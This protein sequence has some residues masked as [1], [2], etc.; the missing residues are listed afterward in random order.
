MSPSKRRPRSKRR[1]SNHAV[2]P[3]ATETRGTK[4]FPLKVLDQTVIAIPLL[5][6]LDEKPKGVA[7]RCRDRRE[8]Q[9]RGRPQ[10]SCTR[11]HDMIGRLAS[12]RQTDRRPHRD[13]PELKSEQYVFASLDA[14]T[15]RA[16]VRM[17]SR[18]GRAPR[19]RR[20][21]YHIWPDF[22]VKR[23][24]NK[25]ISTVKADAAHNAFAA[26]GDDI[27]WAVIDS[28]IDGTHPHFRK[29]RNLGGLPGAVKHRDF[30]TA[31]E[32][33]L[34]DRFGH[35]TS[36]SSTATAGASSSRAST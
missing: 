18:G 11:V 4:G 34:V 31:V 28:G 10:A 15:I 29:H 33:P 13:D 32:A 2:K 9:L 23:L 14:D 24:V 8:P 1:A 35:G 16:L 26:L 30:T 22:P 5:H 19:T 25:S 17:D 6:E 36:R 12:G 7:L 21:I 20:A 3:A 27:I